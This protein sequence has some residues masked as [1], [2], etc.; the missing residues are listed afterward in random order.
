MERVGK[1]EFAKAALN[2]EHET[3]VIY[4]AA[5]TRKD[6][7]NVHSLNRAQITYLK[8][9]KASTEIPNKYRDFE[10]VFSPKLAAKLLEHSVNNHVIELVNDRQLFYGLIYSLGPVKVKTLKTYIK[11]NLASGF[12]RPSKSPTGAPILYD[13]KL[14]KNL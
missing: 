1:K 5:L 13:R 10:D 11:K 4:V 6:L 2:L 14:D 8:A 3:F 9:D 12:I 7:D